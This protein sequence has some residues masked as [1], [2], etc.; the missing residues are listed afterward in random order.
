MV[1]ASNAGPFV[2]SF[3]HGKPRNLFFALECEVRGDDPSRA[4]SRRLGE[5]FRE[6]LLPDPFQRLLI[7]FGIRKFI[8]PKILSCFRA[9]P[10]ADKD[11]FSWIEMPLRPLKSPSH[12]A[13]LGRQPEC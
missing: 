3:V 7:E 2:D 8:Y 1:V 6:R 13:D 9:D 5:R 10:N 11:R 12:R 4:A